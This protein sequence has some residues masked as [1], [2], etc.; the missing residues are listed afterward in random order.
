MIHVDGP[1]KPALLIRKADGCY[2]YA[3]T[4]LAA[5]R[6][7]LVAGYERIVYVT[8]ES[9]AGHFR[10]VFAAAAMAGWVDSRGRN[11]LAGGPPRPVS[12]EHAPFGVVTI[13]PGAGVGPIPPPKKLSSREGTTLTLRSLLD[14]GAAMVSSLMRV[15]DFRT[16]VAPLGPASTATGTGTLTPRSEAEIA[17]AISSSSI[18]YF[19]LSHGRR[20]SY[21]F[22]FDR[23]LQTKGNT[24][25]YLMYGL[26]RLS[27]LRAQAEAALGRHHEVLGGGGSPAAGVTALNGGVV[28]SE[29][30]V[31]LPW[32][33]LA[34]EYEAAGAALEAAAAPFHAAAAAAS[35][36]TNGS[37]SPSSGE[38][39]GQTTPT[40][41]LSHA[42]ERQLAFA[43]VRFPEA[44]H[45]SAQHLA[46]HM[47]AEYL[48]S[49]AGDF[50]AFYGACRVTP[51][52][53]ATVLEEE[54]VAATV[55]QPAARGGRA[56]SAAASERTTPQQP[57]PQRSNDRSGGGESSPPPTPQLTSP[58]S[59]P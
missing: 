55:E 23:T 6:A 36:A 5:L 19:D 46:P 41:P 9:Q 33:R 37:T 30:G 54:A 4:D 13:A 11:T 48:F 38:L 50:H 2:L 10:Q 51:P 31:G 57:L 45:S 22:G 7:R 24:A 12:L 27:A 26:A 56:V 15:G 39:D 29:G 25:A 59:P 58:P 3:T 53:S 44:L 17:E 52:T 20:S 8:D 35:L 1:D 16:P 40:L 32:E 28:N 42:A 14:D 21:A 43:L 34:R 18:R 49:L 47:L